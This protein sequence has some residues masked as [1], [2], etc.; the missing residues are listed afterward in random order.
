MKK[1]TVFECQ[2]E[3]I[4]S[5][6]C[7]MFCKYPGIFTESTH[8]LMEQKV[9]SVCPMTTFL[10]MFDKLGVEGEQKNDDISEGHKH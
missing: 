6:M 10:K 7:D 1:L 9:C 5:T 2:A 4:A 3:T 8:D